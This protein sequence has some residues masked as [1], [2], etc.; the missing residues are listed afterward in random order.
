MD[1]VT[2]QDHTTL[3]PQRRKIMG[4]MSIKDKVPVVTN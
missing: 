1:G 2:K 3:A 4:F